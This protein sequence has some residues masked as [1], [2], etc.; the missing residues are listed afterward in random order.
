MTM[1]GLFCCCCCCCCACCCC[2]GGGCCCCRCC[3]VAVA[4]IPTATNAGRA[5]HNFRVAFMEDLLTFWL[6]REKSDRTTPC[7]IVL[8]QTRAAFT[9][10][11]RLQ[12]CRPCT[13]LHEITARFHHDS[14]RRPF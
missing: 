5:S 6:G 14:A 7:G 2:G 12:P 9:A 3:A 4:A 13:H 1:F 11:S 10:D 8:L